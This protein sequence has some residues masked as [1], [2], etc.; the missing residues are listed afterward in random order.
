MYV[1]T[2]T[3]LPSRETLLWAR[4]ELGG[5]GQAGGR[6]WVGEEVGARRRLLGGATPFRVGIHPRHVSVLRRRHCF[7][8]FASE[9][10]RRLCEALLDAS[11]VPIAGN[12]RRHY[13]TLC[14]HSDAGAPSSGQGWAAGPASNPSI[15]PTS[16]SCEADGDPCAG[17]STDGERSTWPVRNGRCGAI[18]SVERGAFSS[19]ERAEH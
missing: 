8:V 19:V 1:A 13:V 15:A 10:A 5:E 6:C 3:R 12:W 4:D 16:C 11:W 18:L 14:R 7:R 9:E 2:G 17:L